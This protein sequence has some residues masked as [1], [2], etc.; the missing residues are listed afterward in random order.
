[1]RFKNLAYRMGLRSILFTIVFL[2]YINT[3]FAQSIPADSLYI[4]QIPPGNVP[5]RFNL[6]VNKGYFAAERIAISNDG[7]EIFYSQIKGYYP[8]TGES[9]RRYSYSQGKW[10]GPSILFDGYAAPS[11]S[12]NSDTM[13]FEKEFKTYISA[14]NSSAWSNPKW[15]M[16]N[17]DS[18]HYCQSTLSGNYYISSRPAT[19]AGSGDWCKAL[20]NGA[21]TT[22]FSLGRP[23]NTGGENLDFF[24]ARDESFMIVTT[25]LGLGISYRKKDGNWTNPR[26]LGPQINFGLGMWGPYVTD[27]NK[28]LFYSTGTKEDYSDVGV[29]WVRIDGLIDSLKLTNLS[30]YIKISIK[31]QTAYAGQQFS[32]TLPD[33]IFF[34]E[35]SN[36]PLAYSATLADGNK[37]PSWLSFNPAA[38]TFSGIPTDT[39]ELSIKVIVT[40]GDKGS[41]FCPFKIIVKADSKQSKN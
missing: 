21:D 16:T 8:N 40:D 4:G 31:T 11:L 39:G 35:D 3:G 36:L 30:P 29:F 5:K 17:L 28:Y 6:L 13:Y 33:N 27:D 41:A 2:F 7:S 9:I 18:A 19:G 38:R 15:I 14:K 23:L 1:M 34:D 32:F 22:A 24:V 10:S 25:Y 37:L 12:V 20:I 26:N